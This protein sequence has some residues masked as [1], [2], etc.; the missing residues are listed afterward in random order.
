[1]A[2]FEGDT[3]QNLSPAGTPSSANAFAVTMNV[4]LSATDTSSTFIF[5]GE[6]SGFPN[7]FQV[8]AGFHTGPNIDDV[9]INISIS[10]TVDLIGSWGPLTTVRGTQFTVEAQIDTLTGSVVVLENGSPLSQLSL[11]STAGS[12]LQFTAFEWTSGGVAFQCAGDLGL[13]IGTTTP[14]GTPDIFLTIPPAGNVADFLSNSTGTVGAFTSAIH[15][16]CDLCITPPPPL[17]PTP[18]C[19]DTHTTTSF[20]AAWTP[21]P[22][23]GTPTSYEVRYRKEGITG[24]TTISGITEESV[25]I[26]GLDPAS[27]YE[28]QVLASNSVGDSAFSSSAFC[29]TDGNVLPEQPVPNSLLRWRGQV[30]IN[31]KGMA[32]VGDAFDGV[33]GLSDFT[34]FTEYGNTMQFLITTPPL[35][36]DRKRIFVP[37]FEIEVEAGAGLPNDPAVGG[38]ILLDWSKDG[39]ITWS[40]LLQPRSMGAIGEYIKRLRWLNLGNSRTW[41][42]RLRCT[43]QIRRYIIGTYLDQWKGL[44]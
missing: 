24:W 4:I 42:F 25:L 23:G 3:A 10:A 14:V 17:P 15:G 44:G 1:M 9:S 27:V 5:N 32:L 26:T 34:N 6:T 13:W 35:H 43:D 29:G 7:A 30:G 18:F 12:V 19:G 31:W 2:C 8:I 40:T 37:R 20:T 41:I 22:F 38:T 39:G 16:T 21:D 11:F 36:E 28:F 33:V